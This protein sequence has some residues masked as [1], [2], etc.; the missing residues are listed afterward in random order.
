MPEYNLAQ[1]IEELDDTANRLTRLFM[2]ASALDQTP[3]HIENAIASIEA[4]IEQTKT[5]QE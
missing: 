2:I 5:P 1:L 3:D 4:F